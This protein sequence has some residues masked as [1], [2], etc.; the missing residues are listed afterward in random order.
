MR[1]SEAVN[2][3]KYPD[4]VTK[5]PISEFKSLVADWAHVMGKKTGY[6]K[7]TRME[8][9]QEAI[10]IV[11]THLEK[12][13]QTTDTNIIMKD[14]YWDA[15]MVAAFTHFPEH[16]NI[17]HPTL[18]EQ[19]RTRQLVDNSKVARQLKDKAT[20]LGFLKADKDLGVK[21][22]QELA[23]SRLQCEVLAA[24]AEVLVARYKGGLLNRPNAT[25]HLE[26]ERSASAE[27]SG[28]K[29]GGN[30]AAEASIKGSV[31]AG[32]DSGTAQLGLGFSARV[33]T[34]IEATAGAAGYA[35][36]TARL[37]TL[38]ASANA[39]LS[40]DTAV[41]AS[42]DLELEHSCKVKV[43]FLRRMLGPE[44]HLL[45]VRLG[46]SATGRAGGSA[47]ASASA[48]RGGDFTH[49][50]DTKDR[51][52]K[53]TY[54][55]SKLTDDD[56]DTQA[57]RDAEQM[58][59]GDASLDA[60]VE[61]A[62]RLNGTAGI[63]IGQM[64]DID[65][66]GDL[67]AGA[68]GAGNIS[69][70]VNEEQVGMDLGAKLFAGFEVGSNQKISFRHPR[71]GINIFTVRFHESFSTGVGI[72]A[73][74][75]ARA[76]MKECY[77]DTKAGATLGV[78]TSLGIG[79]ALSPNGALLAIYDM[80][81]VPGLTG[82]THAVKTFKPS[83]SYTQTLIGVSNYLERQASKGEINQ[84]YFDNQ[85]R[86]RACLAAMNQD[87]ER[88]HKMSAFRTPGFA[89]YSVMSN[90]EIAAGVKGTSQSGYHNYTTETQKTTPLARVFGSER[91]PGKSDISGPKIKVS[92]NNYIDIDQGMV[93]ET[94][95]QEFISRQIQ[96]QG[97]R[98]DSAIGADK[99]T[100]L[101][102]VTAY[103][104]AKTQGS[105][106][107]LAYELIRTDILNKENIDYA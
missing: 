4:G 43:S 24:S 23:I 87:V 102:A 20:L 40:A 14:P 75:S 30:V 95:N 80:M 92:K 32:Y 104:Q 28:S 49:H 12:A 67:F 72:E 105:G 85:N 97:G 2:L 50:D 73:G 106:E 7:Q 26:G 74:L 47:S 6:R 107:C 98:N 1:F 91:G 76:G 57:K 29:R 61:L 35:D 55:A 16:I 42:A 69:F 9:W 96:V 54:N 63:T 53:T 99:Q 90:D 8:H 34:A 70:T 83:A 59:F 78:G 37:N 33:K 46:A 38:T 65:V 81:V 19:E 64:F 10:D 82:L 13:H 56:K 77:L 3:K 86:I 62:V 17:Y 5:I 103:E 15:M 100:L 39:G 94:V 48:M 22:I 58:V 66:T 44:F 11:Y 52:V 79:S 45:A 84:V 51:D 36:A 21:T 101:A 27:G 68:A 71:R 93:G 89:G 31:G 41:S 18:V 25:T 88:L 60:E